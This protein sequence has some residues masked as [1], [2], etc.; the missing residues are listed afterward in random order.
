MHGNI[1]D[2][3]APK[4]VNEKAIIPPISETAYLKLKLS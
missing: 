4:I 2:I 3:T 1:N